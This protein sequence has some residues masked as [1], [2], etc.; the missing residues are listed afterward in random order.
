MRPFCP[1]KFNAVMYVDGQAV[2]SE[3]YCEEHDCAWWNTRFGMCSQAV[4]AYLKGQADWRQEKEI[5]MKG[6]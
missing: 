2:R 4:D 1:M 5:I 6:G 3:W